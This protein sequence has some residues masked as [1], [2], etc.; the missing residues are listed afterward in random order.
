MAIAKSARVRLLRGYFPAEGIEVVGATPSPVGKI[1]RGSIVT[2]PQA[3]AKRLRD[4]GVAE[5]VF[6][7]D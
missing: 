4:L 5:I 6:D 2:M 7:D 3:E 1:E